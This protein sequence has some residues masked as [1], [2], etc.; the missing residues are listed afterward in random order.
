M[1]DQ[2]D[3]NTIDLFPEELVITKLRCTSTSLKTTK[4]ETRVN[5]KLEGY[6]NARF[7]TDLSNDDYLN[8]A[9]ELLVK[10]CCDDSTLARSYIAMIEEKYTI[11][12]LCE[13][14]SGA[15]RPCVSGGNI[16]MSYSTA[17]PFDMDCL[18]VE[19]ATLIKLIAQWVLMLAK[20]DYHTASCAIN[21]GYLG[22]VNADQ[23]VRSNTQNSH[24]S[25]PSG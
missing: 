19:K 25:Y 22:L 9:A 11:D 8:A 13:F 20:G 3:N 14:R 6:T 24:S 1:K 17:V 7:E 16:S 2:S 5:M 15:K 10:L 12:E 23:K 4:D 18:I 21:T